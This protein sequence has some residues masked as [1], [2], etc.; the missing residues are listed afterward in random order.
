MIDAE[1]RGFTLAF[2]PS[3]AFCVT[4]EKLLYLI[5]HLLPLVYLSILGTLAKSIMGKAW[6]NKVHSPYWGGSGGMMSLKM[7][8]SDEYKM[9][10]FDLIIV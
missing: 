10:R 7:T 9:C 2:N 1:G 8:E 5:M 3:H 4:F 6:G